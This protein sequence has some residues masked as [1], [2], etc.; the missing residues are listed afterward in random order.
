MSRFKV[1]EHDDPVALAVVRQDMGIDEKPAHMQPCNCKECHPTPAYLTADYETVELRNWA[2][3]TGVF[4]VHDIRLPA[5]V[6][7]QAD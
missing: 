2:A 3:D 4:D 7:R 6:R 5:T 1:D